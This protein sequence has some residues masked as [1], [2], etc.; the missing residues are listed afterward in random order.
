MI[1]KNKN[2]Q[3]PE[4]TYIIQGL[5]DNNVLATA[6]MRVIKMKTY[7]TED[8]ELNP[9]LKAAEEALCNMLCYVRLPKYLNDYENILIK[10][11]DYA[12]FEQCC[13]CNG[14]TVDSSEFLGDLIVESIATTSNNV[15]NSEKIDEAIDKS[16]YKISTNTAA[17]LRI[18]SELDGSR[19]V[20]VVYS[21][22]FNSGNRVYRYNTSVEK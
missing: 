1:V 16:W 12:E 18:T 5:R 9:Q 15:S 7:Y 20:A 6:N 11:V 10:A 3:S 17:V 22:S 2:V 21:V 8:L 14:C 13:F 19:L 4:S